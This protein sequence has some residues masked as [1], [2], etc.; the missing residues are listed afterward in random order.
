MAGVQKYLCTVNMLCEGVAEK[1]DA[2][3]DDCCGPEDGP[4]KEKPDCF[5]LTKLIPDAE[6]ASYPFIPVASAGWAIL[7]IAMADALPAVSA[8][9]DFPDRERGPP[10]GAGLFLVQRR[11]LI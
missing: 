5:A 6:K 3:E 10:D 11:L 9:R 1:C 8:S 7:P 2:E 4:R